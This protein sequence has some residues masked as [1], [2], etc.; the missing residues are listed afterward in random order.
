MAL[1]ALEMSQV[2]GR[3]QRWCRQTEVLLVTGPSSS[4]WLCAL[5]RAFPG[6]GLGPLLLARDFGRFQGLGNQAWFGL[7]GA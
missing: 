4:S 2:A 3:S 5:L 1:P 6:A 7:E